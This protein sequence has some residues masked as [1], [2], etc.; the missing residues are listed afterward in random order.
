MWSQS[1]WKGQL[2][3]SGQ[4]PDDFAINYEYLSRGAA[5]CTLQH[6]RKRCLAFYFYSQGCRA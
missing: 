4:V 6:C 2:Y 1:P 3:Q 5:S